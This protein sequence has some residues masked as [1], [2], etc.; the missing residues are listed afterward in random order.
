MLYTSNYI[1]V[2][3]M[4]DV[5]SVLDLPSVAPPTLTSDLCGLLKEDNILD[6]VADITIQVHVQYI[7]FSKDV[8]LKL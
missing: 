6:S 5:C 1:Y 8:S 7:L 3:I 2:L 4:C